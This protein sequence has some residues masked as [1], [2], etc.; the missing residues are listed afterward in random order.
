MLL[1]SDY[2]IAGSNLLFAQIGSDNQ[3]Y[4]K[5]PGDI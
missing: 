5:G 1:N 3:Y 2:E 4:C